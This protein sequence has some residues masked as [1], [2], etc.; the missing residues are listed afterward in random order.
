MNFLR[1]GVGHS[2]RPDLRA[3]D[4][5]SVPAAALAAAAESGL[6]FVPAH[7]I[8]VDYVRVGAGPTVGN[9]WI[10]PAADAIVSLTLP[11]SS[12]A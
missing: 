2:A 8:A 11:D 3:D 9:T 1:L 4:R 12:F 10:A 7:L 6:L 5:A